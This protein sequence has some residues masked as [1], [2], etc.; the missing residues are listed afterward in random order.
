MELVS[1]IHAGSYQGDLAAQID[2]LIEPLGGFAAFFKKGERVFV[3]PNLIM[4]LPVEKAA[5]T[6]PAIILAVVALLKDLGCQVAVGDSPGLGSA[7]AAARRL[8]LLEPLRYYGVPVIEFETET[9]ELRR[10][11]AG[12]GR[13]F[14]D[15]HLAA[16][17]NDFEHII[18]L[19][20]LKSHGQMGL[21]LATKNLFGCVVGPAKAQ[22][23]YATGRDT[24]LFARLLLEVALSVNATLH[25]VDG[26]IGMDG[27][28][29]SHGR[30][31]PLNMLVAGTNPVAVDRV[32]VEL[33]HQK[34]ELIPVMKAAAEMRLAGAALS[35]I[36]IAGQTVSCLQTDPFEIPALSHLEFLWGNP[37]GRVLKKLM[38]QQLR[39][40]R[41]RCV[42]CRKCERQCP[43]GAIRFSNRIKIREA[44]CIKCCC[45]QEICPVGAISVAG[46][47][48]LRILKKWKIL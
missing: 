46:S 21:T 8:N 23:H 35:D 38:N 40:D 6:H 16:E 9:A 32:I 10:T 22:W 44:D 25:I 42:N 47:P 12:M 20:K 13:C 14:K 45:C 19:P 4:A 3:K 24:R 36:K 27:N 11:P 43:A 48:L 39:I 7:A 2:K 41:E 28:G 31:R 26:I 37:C 34:P 18:N 30:P 1:I 15:L 5:T 29:P 33:L 17:L